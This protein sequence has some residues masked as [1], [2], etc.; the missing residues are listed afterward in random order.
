MMYPTIHINGTSKSDLVADLRDS[1][2]AVRAAIR[3]LSEAGPHGRDYYPQGPDA[4]NR[5]IEE[6]RSR[7]SRMESVLKE[8][9]DIAA[10][11][12]CLD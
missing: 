11:I 9:E 1:H 7:L 3:I 4:I 8:L 2:Y 6:H 12:Q 10:H 5:A